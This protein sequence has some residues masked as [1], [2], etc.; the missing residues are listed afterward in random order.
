MLPEPAYSLVLVVVASMSAVIGLV[1]ALMIAQRV[2][3][4]LVSGYARRR[5]RVLT[6]WIHRALDDPDAIPPLRRVL[7]PL[8]RLV[9]RTMLLRLALDLRGEEARAIA[10]LYRELGLLDD[11]LRA[12]SAWRAGRR[13]AAAANLAT[14]RMPRIQRH[15]VRALEDPERRVRI[16]LI[17]AL[18]EI[19]DR[20]A[21]VE[22]IPRLGEKSPLVVRQVEQVL[23]ERGREVVAEIVAFA[24]TTPKLRG[25]RAAVEVLGLLRAPAAA[26]LLLE[27]VRADDRELRIRSVKA[28]AA[29]GDPRF[30]DHFHELLADPVWEVRCQAAKGLGALGSPTSVG[31]LHAALADP[32]WWV[33]FY[34]A[35]ALAEVG[36]PGYK[37]LEA[38]AEDPEPM[39][40]DMARYLIA[41]GPMLPVLP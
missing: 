27:L 13:A 37:A 10:D 26:D 32:H 2:L 31:R 17:R 6:P 21:L 38:A 3:A 25:R 15:L 40:R 22:L 4:S 9:V 14:L 12:L 28:A 34:A 39:V 8:D 7:R 36:D 1:F 18:G 33:R 19:G 11:E 41:R 29:I 35:V 24:A 30:L 23:V 16:A 20:Q 5:E